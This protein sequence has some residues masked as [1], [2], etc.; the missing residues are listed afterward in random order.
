V[1]SDTRAMRDFYADHTQEMDAVRAALAPR[2]G[3]VG[4]LVF[5]GKRWIGLDI[6]PSPGLF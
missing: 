3:Q 5:L 2:A 1:R 6:L 4:A